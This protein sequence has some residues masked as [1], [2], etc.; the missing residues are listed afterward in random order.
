MKLPWTKLPSTEAPEAPEE[1][2]AVRRPSPARRPSP[3]GPSAAD[4]AA[5][6]TVD[7]TA[8]AVSAPGVQKTRARGKVVEAPAMTRSQASLSGPE[9]DGKDHDLQYWL[10]SGFLTLPKDPGRTGM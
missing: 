9:G 10:D 8:A 2:V 1:P 7:T 3:G 6:A 5:D 4:T